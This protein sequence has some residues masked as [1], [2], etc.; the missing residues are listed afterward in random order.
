MA[1]KKILLYPDPL[2][3]VRSAKINIFDKN[4]VNLSKDLIDTMYDADGVGLAAPQIGINKRIFV[5]DCSSEN[6][7]KDCRVVINPEI[8]HASEELG[9]YK[10]G[11][12]SIPGI[13]EEISRPKVIKVL[14]QDVNG[15][16]QRDTY[17]DLWSICFQHELDHLNGKLFIDHLRPMKKI[18]VKNK[19]KKSSKKK[20]QE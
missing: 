13:T 12:L 20:K 19:M 18:L 17:D 15:V 1:V 4:L 6:E 10:E 16:L 7:E 2:L 5:M 3:L 8:E 11:C 14:Y 9:S